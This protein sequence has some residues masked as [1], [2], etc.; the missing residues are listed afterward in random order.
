VPFGCLS[1]N[2]PEVRKNPAI[3]TTQT[4]Y[5]QIF[6]RIL[7]RR[8]SLFMLKR[9][10]ACIL[11]IKC[12]L[13]S[14]VDKQQLPDLSEPLTIEELTQ[15]EK[16]IVKLVQDQTFHYDVTV[17]RAAAEDNTSSVPK[18]SA[19][20]WLE[21]FMDS[22][23]LLRVGGR[24]PSHPIGNPGDQLKGVGHA[25]VLRCSGFFSEHHKHHVTELVIR[26][27]HVAFGH[28]GREHTLAQVRQQYWIIRDRSEVRRVLS[29][30]YRC[31]LR[32]SRPA[33]QRM[34]DLPSDRITPGSVIALC[35]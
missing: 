31:R 18:S 34:A 13:K 14:K 21:L 33:D 26:H 12:Y 25:A 2:D 29:S 1:E 7:Q 16:E 10:I 8:S 3:Y 23:G 32:D 6:D 19:L 17:L 22:N 11:K 24:L 20:Y 4:G 28:C 27:Y 35:L 30:C 9:D 15:A 5:S